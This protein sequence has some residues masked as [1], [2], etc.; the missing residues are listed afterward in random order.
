M[1]STGERESLYITKRI[2]PQRGAGNKRGAA[3]AAGRKKKKER[4]GVEC[5]DTLDSELPD[6]EWLSASR[7]QPFWKQSNTLPL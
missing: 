1:G 5:D 3:A 4:T 6:K 7:F 2:G